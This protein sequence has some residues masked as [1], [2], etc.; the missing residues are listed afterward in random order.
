M[1][2]QQNRPI[3][4][5]TGASRG[6]GLEVARQLAEHSMTVILTARSQEKS[7]A[8]A[9]SIAAG[10]WDIRPK[11]LDVADQASVQRIA[12]ALEQEFGRLDVLVNNAAGFVDWS[13]TTLS[14]DLQ[15]SRAVL[16]TNL[17]GPWQLCQALVPL[18]RRSQHG[19]I[20]NVASGAGSHGEQEFGLSTGR[21]AVASYGI[22]KAALLALTSK[23]A[24][25]LEGSGILV[26]AVCPGFTATA[27]GM[28]AMG[29]R[30]IPEG[31]S[32]VVWAALLPDDGPNGGFFRDGKPLPW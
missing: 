26:N 1:A 10:G 32:G 6:I 4:L 17:F 14:A 7:Q 3:A 24:A 21:G 23:L 25:E 30:S 8:A 9:E 5:V 16:E 12:A 2:D 15:A 28:D 29:A 13:E 22:S 27:P 19:R 18:L 31:A 20:V 11:S